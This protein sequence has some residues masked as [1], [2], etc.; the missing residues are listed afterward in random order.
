M[1]Y[2]DILYE[3]RIRTAWIYLNRPSDMN[4][5]SKTMLLELEDAFTKAKADDNVRVV[6]LS[7]KGKAFCAGTDLKLLLG[8]LKG[9]K[10][11]EPG[12]LDLCERTFG[13]MEHFP[14]PVIAALNGITLAGG[15]ELAMTADLVIAGESI[16]IGDAP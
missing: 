5:I 11:G 8:E 9:E 10:N 13:L 16:K 14:K 4:S 15:L 7:G 2:Q 6:V 12:L 1:N 3:Q